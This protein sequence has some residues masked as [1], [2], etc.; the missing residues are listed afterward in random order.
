MP[1]VF[2]GAFRA[3][4]G[5]TAYVFANATDERQPFSYRKDGAWVADLLPPNGLK[6]VPV[7]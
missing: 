6:L 3:R 7:K 5:R 2:A 4:D 1:T